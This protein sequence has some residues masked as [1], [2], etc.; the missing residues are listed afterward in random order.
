MM[1]PTRA[2]L[3]ALYGALFV[4][5]LPAALIVWAKLSEKNFPLP[6]VQSFPVG[7][8]AAA[9][10]GLLM[11]SG[12]ISL[13]WYGKGLP[14]NAFPPPRF[15]T[16]GAYRLLSHPI[17]V[18]FSLLC[19]GLALLSGSPSALWLVSP[20]VVLSCTALV[21][22][23]ERIDLQERFPAKRTDSFIQ[24]PS[25]VDVRPR[26]ADR[27]S[28]YLL[29]LLPWLLLYQ[30]LKE[31]GVPPNALSS[32]LPFE[33]ELGVI[34]WTEAFYAS[35]YLLVLLAPA[36]AP[37]KR[38]LRD[39]AVKGGA[40]TILMPLFF[41]C[42][43]LVAAPRPFAADSFWGELL[44]AERMLD[45]PANAFPSY[46][47][48]WILLAMRLY[49]QRD[50]HF[51]WLWRS[52]GGAVVLS[53]V[54]TGMHS[55]A[56]VAGGLLLYWAVVNMQS[57]WMW[58]RT[59]AERIANS[60]KEW[61]WTSVRVIN[62]GLYAG[63]GSFLAVAI[64]CQLLGAPYRGAIFFLAC[65]SLVASGLWAQFIEG[66][67]SLLR[68]YGFYG[69][70]LGI[71]VGSILSWPLFGT[72]PWLL[73]GA[74]A[75]AGPFVQSFGRLRCLVQGCCHGCRAQAG[76]GIIYR[77]PRSRVSRLSNLQGVPLHATPLY[78][79][80]WNIVIAALLARLYLAQ[81]PLS[82]VSGLYLILTGIG[83]FVEEAYRGEPQTRILAGLRLYQWIAIGTVLS[84]ALF[85]TLPS[86]G[87]PAPAPFEWVS[88]AFALAF[89]LI[90]WFALGVD[91]PKSN[92]RFARLV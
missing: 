91:F 58:I 69:G 64:A 67:P 90:T 54:T 32:F 15:V 23:Y 77:H 34:Q 78:S 43:P 35:T 10:G 70:V 44:K 79:I 16:Q 4:V 5:V 73:L 87:A 30:V 49:V 19:I 85:T 83:R 55:L 21:W 25:P 59:W 57:L 65:T 88:L 60:W 62:H 41:L 82:L 13:L 76:I 42:I 68:P 22:G 29:I 14:M 28:V 7:V 38:T 47:V 61:Q 20:V 50:W 81:A 89:A 37:S 51:R 11:L 66:S 36:L 18:G 17:Y 12:M 63:I 53:C 8:A 52:L 9:S 84:G 86:A 26:A 80:L 40:A 27:V 46:H 2:L 1:R 48:F 3:A 71:F 24:L 72:D 45:T 74:Y 39:F 6:P 31:L 56:D 75:V 92:R 33:R